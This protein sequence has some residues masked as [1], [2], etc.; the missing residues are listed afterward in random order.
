ML[1]TSRVSRFALDALG[2]SNPPRES[3]PTALGDAP[4]RRNRFSGQTFRYT[5]LTPTEENRE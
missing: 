1:E 5:P 3:G 4:Q 2:A